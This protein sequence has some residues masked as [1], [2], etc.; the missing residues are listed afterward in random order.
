MLRETVVSRERAGTHVS[1]QM[2]LANSLLRSAFSVLELCSTSAL[3]SFY[4]PTS[5]GNRSIEKR[6]R[7]MPHLDGLWDGLC[8]SNI[9]GGAGV[10]S[11]QGVR[12]LLKRL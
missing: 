12:F 11:W 5:T 8:G 7:K 2:L 3:D 9:N 10:L 6:H 4:L 1:S